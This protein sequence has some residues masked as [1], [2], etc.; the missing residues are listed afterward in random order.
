MMVRM[1]DLTKIE[2]LVGYK[3]RYTLEQTLRQ[4]IEL[5]RASAQP[6]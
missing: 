5:E 6:S 4:I 3:P 2:R 1:P